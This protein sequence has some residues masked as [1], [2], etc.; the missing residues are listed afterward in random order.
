M[1]RAG[2]TALLCG[3]IAQRGALAE[4]KERER[5]RGR[6]SERARQTEQNVS[7]LEFSFSFFPCKPNAEESRRETMLSSR[8][9]DKEGALLI[10][11]GRLVCVSGL[12]WSSAF[13]LL[14]PRTWL[15]LCVK[16][17]RKKMERKRVTPSSRRCGVAKAW[18]KR[19]ASSEW[20]CQEQSA[21]LVE[22]KRKRG[23]GGQ[24][25][26]CPIHVFGNIAPWISII[27]EMLPC[28]F[29]V[30]MLHQWVRFY[31]VDYS[32][33]SLHGHRLRGLVAAEW[34]V[35]LRVDERGKQRPRE[36]TGD[37]S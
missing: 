9:G 11:R 19:A 22:R 7:L 33:D 3:T 12:A 1:L 25:L 16:G 6:A 37:L 36:N 28:W 13:H 18:A 10:V 2:R 17:A 15:L 27:A 14:F 21:A 20:M 32:V 34:T 24:E 29:C 4:L 5:E 23:G 30:M 35:L 31:C 8:P 26:F